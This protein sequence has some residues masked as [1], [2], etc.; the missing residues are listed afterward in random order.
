MCCADVVEVTLPEEYPPSIRDLTQAMVAVDHT[1]RP[2]LREARRR[3]SATAL[4]PVAS[5]GDSEELRW[6]FRLPRLAAEPALRNPASE[7]SWLGKILAACLL[8][9]RGGRSSLRDPVA[10]LASF[11]RAFQA[12]TMLSYFQDHP[13]VWSTCIPL[14]VAVMGECGG[15]EARRAELA[16]ATALVLMELGRGNGESCARVAVLYIRYT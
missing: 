15:G 16:A 13:V 8:E 4:E 9:V 11:G 7:A 5:R 10:A 1:T 12:S 3:L 14:A 2:S 6:A